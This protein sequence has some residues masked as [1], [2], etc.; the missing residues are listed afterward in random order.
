MLQ[1]KER[2]EERQSFL[3]EVDGAAWAQKEYG[4]RNKVSI[5]REQTKQLENLQR[6]RQITVQFRK[7]K[8]PYTRRVD[9][10]RRQLIRYRTGDNCEQHRIG[11]GQAYRHVYPCKE[12]PRAGSGNKGLIKH[13]AMAE[14]GRSDDTTRAM[15][16]YVEPTSKAESIYGTPTTPRTSAKRIRGLDQ[17][18]IAKAQLNAQATIETRF[19]LHSSQ[20]NFKNL[21]RPTRFTTPAPL[22]ILPDHAQGPHS[23]QDQPDNSACLDRKP[24]SRRPDASS[25]AIHELAPS[26]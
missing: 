3:R 4:R 23:T 15:F 14:S 25:A 22:S 8:A 6:V 9:S 2:K 11:P 12:D 16:R 7:L 19:E 18:G 5:A 17:E 13:S 21:D 1:F 10:V 20:R 24:S 26:W